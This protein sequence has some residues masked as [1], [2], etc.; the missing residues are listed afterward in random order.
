MSERQLIAGSVQ[1]E[2]TED[3]F[4]QR[5]KFCQVKRHIAGVEP[6]NRDRHGDR[7]SDDASGSRGAIEEV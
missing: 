2:E 7:V 4:C 5:V 3:H 1:P 6:G